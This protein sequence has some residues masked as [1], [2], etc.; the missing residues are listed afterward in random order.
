MSGINPA[1]EEPFEQL[2]YL[3]A[4]LAAIMQISCDPDARTLVAEI[5]RR[6]KLLAEEAGK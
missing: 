6:A 3:V 5:Q 2:A 1:Q 4:S